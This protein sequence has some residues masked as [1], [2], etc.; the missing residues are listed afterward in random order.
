MI[1]QVFRLLEAYSW[2][3]NARELRNVIERMAILNSGEILTP[4][5]IPVEIRIGGDAGP[6]LE[7]RAKPATLRSAITFCACWKRPTGT[8]PAPPARWAWSALIS[9]SASERS[10]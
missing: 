1:P 9:T 10:D 3:G 2:P 7:S 8:S 6:S 5:T 4:E